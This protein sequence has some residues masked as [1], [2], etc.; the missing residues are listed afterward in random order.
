MAEPQDYMRHA[1]RVQ[2]ILTGRG[3][4]L[5]AY[6]PAGRANAMTIGWGS[7]GSVWGMPMWTVL[8]RPSRYTYK[9]IETAGSFAVCVPPADLKKA[10]VVCGSRS[11]R[12]LDKL[13]DLG[14]SVKRG[15][16]LNVPVL[17]DCPIVYECRVVHAN[18]VDPSRLAEGIGKTFYKDPDYHRVYWGRIEAVHC[19]ADAAARLAT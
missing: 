12:D 9:C 17:T 13:A 7:I 10:C 18:D 14:L 3:L 19:T 16:V 5:T 8:V 15:D 11:G 2:D 6:D 1:D 4:L